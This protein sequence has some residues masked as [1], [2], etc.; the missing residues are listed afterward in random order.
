MHSPHR[1][2]HANEAETEGGESSTAK[3]SP[4]ELRLSLIFFLGQFW[5]LQEIAVGRP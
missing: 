3:V 2:I 4:E 5:L 1:L